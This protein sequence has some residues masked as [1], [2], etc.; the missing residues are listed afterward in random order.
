M[1]ITLESNGGLPW[2]VMGGITM[3]I[4]GVI[5]GR[6][7]NREALAWAVVGRIILECGRYYPK[8]KNKNCVYSATKS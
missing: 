4:G 3:E 7:H 5:T 2:R 6:G 8:N 1:G